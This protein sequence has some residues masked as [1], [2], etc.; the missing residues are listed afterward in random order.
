MNIRHFYSIE[1][2]KLVALE[3]ED[4]IDWNRL[5]QQA[6]FEVNFSPSG[7]RF[8][9]VCQCASNKGSVT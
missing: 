1:P 7:T 6:M 8:Q 3:L 5:F 4:I 9:V 2:K